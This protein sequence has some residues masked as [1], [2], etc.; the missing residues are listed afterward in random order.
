MCAR[1]R[2][3]KAHTCGK[4]RPRG[5]KRT[6]LQ[7]L[8]HSL[9]FEHPGQRMRCNSCNSCLEKDQQLAQKDGV[10]ARLKRERDELKLWVEEHQ[11]QAQQ[12]KH[13]MTKR[14]GGRHATHAGHSKTCANTY[15]GPVPV[16]RCRCH[17]PPGVRI[18][19][20]AGTCSRVARTSH[21]SRSTC[22][23]HH[24]RCQNRHSRRYRAITAL[25]RSPLRSPLP[26]HSN[27]HP[28]AAPAVVLACGVLP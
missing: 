8:N 6:A 27:H 25:Q 28:R 17:R 23:T 10:I 12:H 14:A 24:M 26:R 3:H 4:S 11:A 9:E 21:R 13:M 22:N 20:P 15:P 16:H 5:C 7:A 1:P 19:T 2:S 18:T